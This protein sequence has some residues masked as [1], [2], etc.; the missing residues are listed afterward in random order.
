MM[1][2]KQFTSDASHELRTPLS[3]ILAQGEYI[4]EIAYTDKEK[5]LVKNIV[6]KTNQVSKLVSKLLTL[7]RIDN[8]KQKINLEKLDVGVLMYIAKDGLQDIAGD[9]KINIFNN[10]AENTFIYADESLM[11]TVFN[12]LI[13]N[14]VKY[15]N[16]GGYVTLNAH[17]NGG[18]TILTITD[19][20][21]GISKENIGKIWER[22]YRVD[23][24]RNDGYGSTGLGLSMTKEI[25]ELHG[26]H[27]TVSSELGKGTEFNIYLND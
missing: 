13:S 16:N 2:E 20:G 10:V 18:Q 25:V 12:N 17:K 3:V 1:K 24:V 22:F 6:S 5:E 23:D 11:I 4:L 14:A 19:N 9:K 21:V 7:S 26:G 27:I 8:H 15:G